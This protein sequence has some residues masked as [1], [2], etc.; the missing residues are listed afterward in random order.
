MFS[1]LRAHIQG[2]FKD[3]LE[4]ETL[5]IEGIEKLIHLLFF[6]SLASIGTSTISK[7]FPLS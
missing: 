1:S 4:R 6:E 3:L 5:G 7:H 2:F